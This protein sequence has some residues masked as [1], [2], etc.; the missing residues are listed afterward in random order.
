MFSSRSSLGLAAERYSSLHFLERA[1]VLSLPKA[2]AHARSRLKARSRNGQ[3]IFGNLV[4]NLFDD[5]I[6]TDSLGLPFKIQNQAVSQNG[7]RHAAQVVARD[8]I[9]TVENCFD[10]GA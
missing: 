5:I 8:M 10:L 4:E 2:V 7:Q 1:I 6:S 9:S 3:C